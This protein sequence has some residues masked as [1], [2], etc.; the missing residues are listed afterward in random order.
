[1]DPATGCL[2]KERGKETANVRW[3]PVVHCSSLFAIEAVQ[4]RTSATPRDLCAWEAQ[5]LGLVPV[6]K[7]RGKT[8]S[9]AH[10]ESTTH[11]SA[12]PCPPS[13][14]SKCHEQD[15]TRNFSLTYGQEIKAYFIF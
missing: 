6:Q 5:P 9:T 11:I 15:F 12:L 4:S 1:M 10:F 3:G 7:T 2:N 14:R 13:S 8:A